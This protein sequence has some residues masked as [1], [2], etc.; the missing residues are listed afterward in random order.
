MNKKKVES[1]RLDVFNI[2]CIGCFKVYSWSKWDY[3]WALF[4]SLLVYLFPFSLLCFLFTFIILNFFP[5]QFEW[6]FLYIPQFSIHNITSFLFFRDFS[7]F[8]LLL[9]TRKTVEQ[10]RIK[11]KKIKLNYIFY[12]R[13]KFT[14]K[15]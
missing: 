10:K 11:S 15:N 3:L 9:L 14:F 8:F 5:P 4:I 7:R 12:F 2:Q 13:S 1:S 6:L